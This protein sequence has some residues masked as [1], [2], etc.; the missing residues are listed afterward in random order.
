M[1]SIV[2]LI[3]NKEFKKMLLGPI[4]TYLYN[5]CVNIIPRKPPQQLISFEVP[6]INN[7]VVYKP[8]ARQRQINK[9]QALLSNS[10]NRKETKWKCFLCGPCRDVSES[11]GLRP[12]TPGQSVPAPNVDSVPIDNMVRAF[13]VVQQIMAEFNNAV[14]M[15]AKVQAITRIVLTFMEENGQ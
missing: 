13:T 11:L 15:E 9:Q 5:F 12:Q 8:V 4:G 6:V 14:S 3:A 7:I 1:E 10:K 2:I